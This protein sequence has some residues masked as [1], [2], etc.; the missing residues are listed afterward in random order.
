MYYDI[1]IH[2][3][4]NTFLLIFQQF[5]AI[6]YKFVTKILFLLKSKQNDVLVHK[7]I[8]EKHPERS[9]DMLASVASSTSANRIKRKLY[10]SGI[11]S[12]VI[13]TPHM[14]TK[15]GCGYCLRFDDS[16]KTTVEQVAL[17]FGIKIRAFYQESYNENK[18][19]YHKI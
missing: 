5:F 13:Q 12:S 1:T 14:L 11:N 4:N 3:Y 17:E 16:F 9:N 2:I 19:V 7:I 6:L 10:E 8:I 18:K 15:E